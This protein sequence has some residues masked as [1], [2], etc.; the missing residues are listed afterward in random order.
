MACKLVIGL[1]VHN[2]KRKGKFNEKETTVVNRQGHCHLK[3]QAGGH[4]REEGVNLRGDSG[5]M[6]CGGRSTTTGDSLRIMV[7]EAGNIT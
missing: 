4:R 1:V 5:A 6:F 3:W 2:E 7:W